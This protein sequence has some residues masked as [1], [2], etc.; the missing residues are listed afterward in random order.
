MT[1]K[2]KQQKVNKVRKLIES[3]NGQFFTV[4]FHKRSNGQLR[5]MNCR[6]GVKF[7]LKGGSLP[8]DAK[9]ANIIP[10]YETND[11]RRCI[12]LEAVTYFSHKGQKVTF[13]K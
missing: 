5:T 1:N 11:Q 6:I 8:Y 10:V 12:P 2:Q 3:T 9:Q 13:L 7:D 4:K